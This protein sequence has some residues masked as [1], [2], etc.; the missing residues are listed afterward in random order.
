MK[1]HPNRPKPSQVCSECGKEL[2]RPVARSRPFV[3]CGKE[4]QR[5]RRNRLNSVERTV[6]CVDCKATFVKPAGEPGRTRNRCEPCRYERQ[7]LIERERGRRYRERHPEKVEAA[8]AARL[9]ADPS[10]RRDSTLWQLYELT[11]EQYTAMETAQGGV[12]AICGNPP[13]GRGKC[14]VLVVDHCHKTGK[15]RSLLCGKC[16]IGIGCLEDDPSVLERGAAYLRS[17]L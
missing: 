8:K 6:V 11:L 9:P 3:T 13:K 14:D 4:C 1:R 10:R 16:N 12:C 5:L 17:W 15:V 2:P 7:L